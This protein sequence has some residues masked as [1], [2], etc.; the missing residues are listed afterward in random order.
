MAYKLTSFIIA[1]VLVGLFVGG[2][3]IFLNQGAINYGQTEYY[4]NETINSYEKLDNFTTQAEE[5]RNRSVSIKT[6][7]AITDIIGGYIKSAYSALVITQSSYELSVDMAQDGT[8]SAKLGSF[9]NLIVVA[10]VT[11]LTIIFFVG[12]LLKA[13]F[14]V[15]L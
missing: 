10:L 7:T 4:T 9:K 2:F 14:K 5:L 12:I 8:S 13:V 11:I 6:E 15:E 1:M 3:G